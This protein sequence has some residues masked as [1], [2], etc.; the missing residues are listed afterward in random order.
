MDDLII[1]D[2]HQEELNFDENVQAHILKSTR[3]GKNWAIVIMITGIFTGVSVLTN[4]INAGLFGVFIGVLLGAL[5]FL[6]YFVQYF[7]LN[8]FNKGIEKAVSEDDARALMLGL[9]DL[10]RLFRFK[11]IVMIVLLSIFFIALLLFLFN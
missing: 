3:N 2:T 9:E 1:D 11:A 7:F 6:L 5:G 8:N 4:F 10:N